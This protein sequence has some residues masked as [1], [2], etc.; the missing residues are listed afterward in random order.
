MQ[1]GHGQNALRL[2]AVFG[3]QVAA[4]QQIEFLVRAAQLQVAFERYRVVTLHQRVQKLMHADRL[5]GLEAVVKII[6][7]HHAGDV[8][9]RRQLDHAACAQ[10][11][12][13]LAVVANLRF[14]R[15]KH[16]TGLLVVS[17]GVGFDLLTAQR[18]AGRVAAGRV[19]DHGG[20]VADQKNHRVTQIL[21]L[22]HF[23]KHDGVPDMNV[24]RGRVQAEFDPQRN[25]GGFGFGQFLNPFVFR[26]QFFAAAQRHSECIPY[27]I[28]HLKFCYKFLIHKGFSK[29]G[30]ECPRYNLRFLEVAGHFKWPATC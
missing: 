22:S 6:A 8:V 9:T 1:Q 21:Q 3:L 7:L 11:V 13:P 23:V 5:A 20:E 24:R 10:R 19:A 17:L 28:G 18:R 27:T 30:W 12:A 2:L 25:A 16:Q 14:C 15:V 29:S 26:N 4:H